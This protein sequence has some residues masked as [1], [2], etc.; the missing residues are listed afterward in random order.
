MLTRYESV[1]SGWRPWSRANAL[2]SMNEALAGSLVY[3]TGF[4]SSKETAGNPGSN[5]GGRTNVF[6]L[7]FAS[8]LGLDLS[9]GI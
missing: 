3:D 9:Q 8:L 1:G 2:N 6:G 5:P 4:P 7:M